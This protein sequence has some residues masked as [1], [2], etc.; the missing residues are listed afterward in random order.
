MTIDHDVLAPDWRGDITTLSD[1]ELAQRHDNLV[2]AVAAQT[3]L[4]DEA[5][6][7]QVVEIVDTPHHRAD[8]QALADCLNEYRRRHLG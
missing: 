2:R 1:D 3:I 7:W 8:R 6:T 4:F 5:R